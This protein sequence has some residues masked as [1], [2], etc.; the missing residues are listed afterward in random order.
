MTNRAEDVA[1][2]QRN[3]ATILVATPGRLVDIVHHISEFNGP[4]SNPFIRGF[5]SLEVL[6]LDEAD[7]LLEM[8]FEKQ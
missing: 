3:G 6:I 7:R 4:T 1:N 5:R 8:G 2:F